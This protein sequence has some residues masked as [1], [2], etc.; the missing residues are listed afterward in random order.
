MF[1][2]KI[3]SGATVAVAIKVAKRLENVGNSLLYV[4]LRAAIGIQAHD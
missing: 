1:G 2:S 4:L 3:S